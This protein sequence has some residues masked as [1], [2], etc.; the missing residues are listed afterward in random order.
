VRDDFA[1][2]GRARLRAEVGHDPGRPCLAPR[3]GVG[4][5]LEV[6]D[7]LER[8]LIVASKLGDL[9]GASRLVAADQEGTPG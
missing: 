1:D 8:L 5:G 9:S 6:D 3:L 2:L 7:E 4:A